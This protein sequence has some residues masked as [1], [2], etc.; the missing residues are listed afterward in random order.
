MRPLLNDESSAMDLEEEIRWIQGTLVEL[1]NENVRKVTIC[2]RSKRWWNS[3]IE[4]KRKELGRAK[5]K[6]RRWRRENGEGGLGAGPGRG[7]ITN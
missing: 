1:L 2:A 6:R 4:N 5:R 7:S 3:E